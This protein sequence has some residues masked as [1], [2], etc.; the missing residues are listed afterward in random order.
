MEN[1]FIIEDQLKQIGVDKQMTIKVA[2][3]IKVAELLKEEE[4]HNESKQ[5]VQINQEF[6]DNSEDD[7]KQYQ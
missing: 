2:D 3:T 1:N 6:F 7:I 5:G 4:K